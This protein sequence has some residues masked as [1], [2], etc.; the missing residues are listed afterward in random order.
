MVGLGRMGA[1]M[2]LRLIQHDH[3]VVAWDRN[4]ESVK[5]VRSEGAE[6]VSALEDLVKALE[7]PRAVWLM[8]PSGDPTELTIKTLEGVLDRGDI[9]IDGGNSNFRFAIQDAERLADKGIEFI[10]AGVSGGVWG[11]KEG[12]CLMVGGNPEPVKHL[13]PIFTAL[14]PE[15]GYAHVGPVGAGH[16]VKMVHNGVEYGLLQAYAEGFALMHKADE[17]DLDLHQIA[18]IWR[19]GSVVRS[20]LLDLAALALANQEEFGKIRGF[21]EDSG[22]GRWTIDEAVARGV[23][24]PVMAISL[25]ERFQ[26]RETDSFAAKIIAALRNQFGGHKFFEESAGAQAGES[27]GDKEAAG[28]PSASS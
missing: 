11:L 15:N 22:E 20:W 16:F 5:G 17:F 25:F 4:E 21:V 18:E 9:I 3:E 19:Y 28:E 26:S 8:L 12:Y 14:A 6:G 27:G 1:N 10:D 2:T 23:A 13:E 24:T 7:P